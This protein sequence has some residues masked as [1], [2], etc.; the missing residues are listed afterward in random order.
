MSNAELLHD[1]IKGS[2]LLVI[3]G[4]RHPAYLD[5]PELWHKELVGFLGESYR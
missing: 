3:E 4:A 2:K 5:D 1:K